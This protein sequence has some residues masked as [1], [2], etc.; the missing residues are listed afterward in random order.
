MDATNCI[1]KDAKGRGS[2]TQCVLP[3]E[4]IRKFPKDGLLSRGVGMP[5][6]VAGEKMSLFVFFRSI[7]RLLNNPQYRL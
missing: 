5:T 6:P 7:E 1:C 4:A 2:K 3:V